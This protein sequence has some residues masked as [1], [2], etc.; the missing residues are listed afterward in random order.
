MDDR[1]PELDES[2]RGNVFEAKNDVEHISDGYNVDGKQG[3]Q[4]LLS[5]ESDIEIEDSDGDGYSYLQSE[6]LLPAD[7][8]EKVVPF[9]KK[10]PYVPGSKANDPQ[11]NSQY[12]G[13]TSDDNKKRQTVGTTRVHFADE[14]EIIDAYSE[15]GLPLQDQDLPPDSQNGCAC[16]VPLQSVVGSTEKS[17]ENE[18]N[19]MGSSSILYSDNIDIDEDQTLQGEELL[20]NIDQISS[21]TMI[22]SNDTNYNEAPESQDIFNLES[23]EYTM[24]I[25]RVYRL[26]DQFLPDSS[27]VDGHQSACNSNTKIQYATKWEPAHTN[28]YG[29]YIVNS[30]INSK[31]VSNQKTSLPVCKASYPCSPVLYYVYCFFNTMQALYS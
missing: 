7:Q 29:E 10:L 4:G 14:P 12:Q 30:D 23:A 5:P 6:R 25:E 24:G 26:S 17:K 28:E 13:E 20:L 27:S 22:M 21:L 19:C 16:M 8:S 31:S 11:F 1:G 15:K 9:E 18:A 2:V 3:T